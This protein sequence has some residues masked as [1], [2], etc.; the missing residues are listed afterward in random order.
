MLDESKS[1]ALVALWEDGAS[2]MAVL[3]SLPLDCSV[4]HLCKPVTLED[5]ASLVTVLGWH[6]LACLVGYLCKPLTLE[7]ALG[8]LFLFFDNALL[9]LS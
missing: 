7:E 2:L 3:G 4:A 5:G 8:P 9:E 6:P 1:L